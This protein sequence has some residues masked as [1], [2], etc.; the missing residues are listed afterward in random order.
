[1]DGHGIDGYGHT[2]IEQLVDRIAPFSF[3]GDLANAIGETVSGGFCIEK[4]EH[5]L[6]GDTLYQLFQYPICSVNDKQAKVYRFRIQD[7]RTAR[8]PDRM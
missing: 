7:R 3:E 2:R 5:I 1:M 4:D 8:I 6:T